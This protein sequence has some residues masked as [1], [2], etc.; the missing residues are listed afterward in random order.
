MT[1]R[2]LTGR[3]FDMYVTDRGRVAVP[4][5][6]TADEAA[7]HAARV[8]GLSIAPARGRAAIV[9]DQCPTDREWIGLGPREVAAFALERETAAVFEGDVAAFARL[10]E[11]GA[12]DPATL[13]DQA[14][15]LI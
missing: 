10:V 1:T 4:H 8:L 11:L 15:G 12:G 7:W 13:F 3:E 5:G 14:D 9:Q 6:A 2:E